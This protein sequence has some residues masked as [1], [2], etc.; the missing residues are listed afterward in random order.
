MKPERYHSE[1][2]NG[3]D[4]GRRQGIWGTRPSRGTGFTLV[5]L[6]VVIAV[7][8][9]LAAILLP[10]LARARESARRAACQNNLRQFGMVFAMYADENDGYFPP[11][12]PFGSVRADGL[13]SPLF[14]APQGF[15]IVPEYLTDPGIARCASDTGGDPGWSSVGPRV[16]A[17]P[18]DFPAWQTSAFEANDSVSYDYYLSAELA[19]SYMYKGYLARNRSEYFGIWGAKTTNPPE[20]DA[21][22]HGHDTVRIKDYSENLPIDA[23]FWPAW[24]PAPPSATGAHG[25][26]EAV[27]IRRGAERFYITDINDPA[28]SSAA[29]S[30]IAVMWDTFGSGE[31][32]DT[33]SGGIV[34]NHIAGGSNVLH[35]DGHVRFVRYPG[36]F[37]IMNDAQI[38]K[39]NSH[40][41]LG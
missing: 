28:S 33:D 14:E 7:I 10:A 29:E 34:F 38:V 39:E 3:P 37:P 9:I 41:G 11:A 32:A 15:S 8:G 17:G 24:V 40:H 35:L 2:G 4:R 1:S 23:G 36:E 26:N 31:F 18:I 19:R 27:R 21:F 25:S 13:S 5:E 22:I 16:P 12:A 30:S 6:L 20:S